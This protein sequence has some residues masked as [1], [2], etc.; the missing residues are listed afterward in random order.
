[1][2]SYDRIETPGSTGNRP[3]TSRPLPRTEGR[4]AWKANRRVCHFFYSL[5]TCSTIVTNNFSLIY[6]LHWL[7]ISNHFDFYSISFVANNFYTD[8][9]I[10]DWSLKQWKSIRFFFNIRRNFKQIKEIIL[11]LE[12]SFLVLFLLHVFLFIRLLLFPLSKS[13]I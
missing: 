7:I 13:L 1:M 12:N 10:N 2:T 3:P 9:K 8:E 5:V 6:L 11:I 4:Q